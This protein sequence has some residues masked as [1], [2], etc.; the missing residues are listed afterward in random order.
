MTDL[1]LTDHAIVRMAQRGIASRDIDL[2]MEVG[3]EVEGGYLV[4]KKDIE[5]VER[6]MRSCLKRLQ[7]IE[8]K[9]IVVAD[10]TLVTAF[11]A[12]DREQSRLLQSH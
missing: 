5:T 11:H 9:R 3:T 4:R 12:S 8:G 10:G 2:I 6:A 7:K 1:N